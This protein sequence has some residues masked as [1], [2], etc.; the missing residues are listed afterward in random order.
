MKRNNIIIMTVCVL[1]ISIFYASF[2]K[3]A[4]KGR[5]YYEQTGQVLWDIQ[6]EEKV[7]ALTFDDGPDPRY[8]P[9][10]LDLLAKYD[11]K[12]TFFVLGKSAEKYPKIIERAYD[13]GH[14]LAN[15]TYSHPFKARGKKLVD[16]LNKT[17]EIIEG[18][19]GYSPVLFR[20][21]GGIYTDEMINTAQKSGFKVVIWSWHLDTQDWKNPGV[22]RIVRK[23][24]NG[25]TPGD[26]I[27]F[28]DG[29]GNRT[30]TIKSLEQIL[31]ILQKKGYK[32][33]TI[34]ELMGDMNPK[35][36]K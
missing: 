11:A 34:S 16:E 36:K 6:T 26:V 23:V 24:L 28:H 19:T 22:R 9:E 33:V 30:Q 35:I 25:T 3:A 32:F 31:P 5:Y 7:I 21:V 18:I 14:E 2:S 29:G 27:L 13:E 17:N 20:P 1:V 8:T 12:A 15:H 10:I 4:D